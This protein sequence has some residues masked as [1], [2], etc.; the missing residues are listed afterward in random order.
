MSGDLEKKD[1]VTEDHEDYL[2]EADDSDT[3]T[4]HV[5]KLL[6]NRSEVLAALQ[7][8]PLAVSFILNSS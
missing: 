8:Q 3:P 2:G 5:N 1:E 6:L 4:E 7:A